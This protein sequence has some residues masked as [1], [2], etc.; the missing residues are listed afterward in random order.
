MK[1]SDLKELL[2]EI[3]KEEKINYKDRLKSLRQRRGEDENGNVLPEVLGH[4]NDTLGIKREIS[5]AYRDY[6]DGK[7]SWEKFGKELERLMWKSKTNEPD[8]FPK[9][10][11]ALSR[12]VEKSKDNRI[13]LKEVNHDIDDS[14]KS[15]IAVGA[16]N[17][18]MRWISTHPQVLKD[19]R[20]WVKDC[21][22]GD[23]HDETDID[24][25][26]D[27]QILRGVNQYY[28][29]GI[30]Q[31][32]A[33]SNQQGE[34][35]PM[36]E[37]N[38]PLRRKVNREIQ[39]AIKQ[40]KYVV[41]NDEGDMIT[42]KG[43]FNTREEANEKW[44]REQDP[45]VDDEFTHFIIG[46]E[47]L[48]QKKS[49]DRGNSPSIDWNIPLQEED[50]NDAIKSLDNLV[51]GSKPASPEE[52]KK[53]A[54]QNKNWR[55]ELKNDPDVGPRD[56]A[57]EGYGM[58]DMSK[59]KKRA[60]KGARWTVK[61]DEQLNEGSV[62]WLKW[63]KEKYGEEGKDFHSVDMGNG[64]RAMAKIHK[65]T[66]LKTKS[67]MVGFGG[68]SDSANGRSSE[69]QTF[70]GLDSDLEKD[71]GDIGGPSLGGP[72]LDMDGGGD[73]QGVKPTGELR[74]Q[75]SDKFVDLYKGGK[76]DTMDALPS[77]GGG[78]SE[79][80]KK[81]DLKSIIQ[82]LI[83]EIHPLSKYMDG[84]SDE[85][86]SKQTEH[87]HGVNVYDK[88]KEFDK[89]SADR[90]NDV[91]SLCGEPYNSNTTHNPHNLCSDCDVHVQSADLDN[92]HDHQ[93]E[94]ARPLFE[95]KGMTS[96]DK[97]KSIVR[98]AVNGIMNEYEETEEIQLIKQIYEMADT[99]FKSHDDSGKV[100]AYVEGIR[101]TAA[102]LLQM[103]KDA[104]K[105]Q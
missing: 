20:E 26:S 67:K 93:A 40:G 29:G 91:C 65:P 50:E 9:L 102:K 66:D 56:V 3:L 17:S 39:K 6:N 53:A 98:E 38:E 52:L 11:D 60:F 59:D 94:N 63:Q 47:N 99:A 97:L 1:K 61:Y 86:L 95:A 27:E 34:P 80:I 75:G 23:V 89:V 105:I 82:E 57:E 78:M 19:M 87:P 24:E 58:G 33:D 28:D 10:K 51:K 25:M 100:L 88:L 12:W 64:K 74:A 35:A 46:P 49:I 4:I 45:T 15:T 41:V 54:K 68:D 13:K 79:T 83:N 90:D 62:D 73:D 2:L 31:F 21:Q 48:K 84:D 69:P 8:L 5:N 37:A 42:I 36:E 14:G 7:L 22:W 44:Q 55:K 96:K 85:D 30:K 43:V 81:S 70:E 16:P 71:L 72:D 32:M 92:K 101:T 76:P 103:H 104:G 18:I 77:I